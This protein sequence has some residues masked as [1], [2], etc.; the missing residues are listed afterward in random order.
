MLG[1][2]FRDREEISCHRDW[3]CSKRKLPLGQ[4][5]LGK[6]VRENGECAGV[7]ELVLQQQGWCYS[8]KDSVV[9]TGNGVAATGMV[10]QQQEMVLQQ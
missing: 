8:N 1:R 7:M 2:I 4:Q 6:D 9:V 5:G 10:L 3:C